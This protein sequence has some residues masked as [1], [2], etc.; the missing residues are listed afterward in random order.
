[1]NP[2]WTVVR[3]PSGD[4]S[5]APVTI[6]D[7]QGRIVCVVSAEEFRRSRL[8]ATVDM[9]AEGRV[10]PMRTRRALLRARVERRPGSGDARA[11]H[12]PIAS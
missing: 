12:A 5:I 7:A 9:L 10:V 1:M 11:L 3:L 2:S 8:V 4:E 6:L